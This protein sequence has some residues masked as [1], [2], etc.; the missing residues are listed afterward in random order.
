MRPDARGVLHGLTLAHRRPDLVRAVLEGTAI[1]LRM[2]V[3]HYLGDEDVAKLVALGGGARSPL[4]CS[5][6]A[7]VF[8]RPILV[9]RVVEGGALGAA[10][11][12]AVGTG[13]ARSYLSLAREWIR[14]DREFA[15]EPDLV[16][17]YAERRRAFERLEHTL[18]RP[19]MSD[20]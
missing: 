19:P 18:E 6:L 4:W 1:W 15:P 7:A 10:M 17:I 5:I 3:D 2:K 11:L 8:D 9:P 16:E 13:L 12:A 20:P 14:V